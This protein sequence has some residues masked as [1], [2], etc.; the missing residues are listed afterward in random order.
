MSPL[1]SPGLNPTGVPS[2]RT[3][4]PEGRVPG[5]RSIPASVARSRLGSS[6]RPAVFHRHREPAHSM[7]LLFALVIPTK[8]ESAVALSYSVREFV[9]L[10]FTACHP[11]RSEGPLHS[12]PATNRHREFSGAARCPGFSEM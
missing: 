7:D 8:E 1:H 5:A 10:I 4:G 2:K 3:G 6:C 11:E 12:Q 9:I